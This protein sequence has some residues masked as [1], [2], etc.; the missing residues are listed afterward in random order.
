M[1]IKEIARQTAEKNTN[2]TIANI[3]ELD[4]VDVNID[5][6]DKTFAENTEKQF[7]VTGFYGN[8]GKFYRVPKSVLNQLAP[9]FEV[10]DFE[11]F[12]VIKTGTGMNTQYTV[13]IIE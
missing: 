5:L 8:D 4:S 1:N 9:L 2:T 13:R 7:T 12:R 11:K 3:A 10:C 6:I